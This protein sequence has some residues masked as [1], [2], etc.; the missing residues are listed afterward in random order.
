MLL[1]TIP[2]NY[3][4]SKV[5]GFYSLPPY[6]L[7]NSS[8]QDEKQTDDLIDDLN[9]EKLIIKI[10]YDLFNKSPIEQVGV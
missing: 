6:G 3:K 2:Q 5:T 10:E 8:T 4:K 9:L 7:A 1:P